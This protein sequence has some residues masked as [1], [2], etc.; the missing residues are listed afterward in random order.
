MIPDYELLYA[1]KDD[2]V[3][4]MKAA[5][6]KGALLKVKDR[7]IGLLEIAQLSEAPNAARYLIDLGVNVD[8]RLGRLQDILLHRCARRGDGGMMTLLLEAG[9][10]PNIRNLQGKTPLDVA[11]S[12]GLEYMCDNLKEHGATRTASLS[13]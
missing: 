5:L 1:V 10:D 13:L 3:E 12:K 11:H 9:A 7:G 6:A 2:S 8:E 4:E